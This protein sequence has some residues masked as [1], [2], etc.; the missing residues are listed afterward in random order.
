MLH[1]EEFLCLVRTSILR[2][3]IK[4]SYRIDPFF[5]I[6][7]DEAVILSLLCALA[8]FHFCKAFSKDR[9]CFQFMSLV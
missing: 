2:K 9:L 3:N 6:R 8:P 4:A 7:T 1:K 5:H